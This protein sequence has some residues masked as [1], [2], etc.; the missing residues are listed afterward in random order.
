MRLFVQP[1]QVPPQV[2]TTSHAALARG[3]VSRL[4]GS[5]PVAQAA[6]E[7]PFAKPDFG[8]RLR[9]AGV[10]A[11]KHHG[12]P[13]LAI[14]SVDGN[15]P[16]VY[17]VGAVIDTDL[18]LQDVS[19]RTA[20]IVMAHNGAYNGPEAILEMP[21]LAAAERGVL[22]PAVMPSPHGAPLMPAGAPMESGS[23]GRDAL[24]GMEA[25]SAGAVLRGTRAH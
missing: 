24:S 8:G 1:E 3:D 5:N 25:P 17:R 20:T 9:L 21:A 14:I 15:P 4:L 6:D 18:V 7:V 11:P 22:P 13:G 10:A 12:G 2:I 16:R 23:E 19:W